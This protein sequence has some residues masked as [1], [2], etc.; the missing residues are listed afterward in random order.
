MI[1]SREEADAIWTPHHPRIAK[2]I[3][4]AWEEWKAVRSCRTESGFEP[5]LYP[6]TISNY[7]FDA[8]A[9]RAFRE[10]GPDLA[11]QLEIEAQTFKIIHRG[12][13]ARF[14]KSGEGLLGQNHPT[15]AALDFMVAENEL[16]GLPPE[17][18]KVEI[19]WQG[20]ELFTDLESIHMIARDGGALVWK[21][22]IEHSSGGAEV[23]VLP[24]NQGPPEDD[25]DLLITPKGGAGV[26]PGQV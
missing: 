11:F 5:I 7:I 14:K 8:I 26:Q 3:S 6:R 9:R 16:P 25:P 21:S 18:G 19:V 17:T 13:I 20:N 12:S 10:F 22:R 24:N 23:V 2:V 1:P 15:Q 4:G